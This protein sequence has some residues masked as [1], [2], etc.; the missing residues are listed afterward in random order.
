MG[1]RVGL[2][3]RQLSDIGGC[4]DSDLPDPAQFAGVTTRLVC[5]VDP[6]TDELEVRVLEDL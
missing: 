5:V 1:D 2:E 6:D 4:D 3:G